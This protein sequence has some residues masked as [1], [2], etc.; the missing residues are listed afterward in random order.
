MDLIQNIVNYFR[1]N[2]DIEKS[3]DQDI[4]PEGTCPVC[5]GYQQYDGKIREVLKDRQIDIN[6]HKDS[7]MLIQ[8]FMKHN[9]DGV[10]LKKGI[11]T[12][13]PHCNDDHKDE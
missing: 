2:K 9:I 4:S 1:E 12:E 5:W 7:Y 3:E 13:C 8:D 10:R 11:V 6:N